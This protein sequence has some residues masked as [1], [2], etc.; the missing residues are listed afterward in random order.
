MRDDIPGIFYPG[1]CGLFGGARE[2]GESYEACIRRE[3]FEETSLD[4]SAFK[5]FNDCQL[6]F[7][8]FGYGVV[9]RIFFEHTIDPSLF[10]NIQLGEGRRADLVDAR[11]LLR[12]RKISPYDSFVLWQ[13]YVMRLQPDG[14]GGER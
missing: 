12:E 11:S 8:P 3:V 6:S 14:P 7:T 5:R 10:D 2:Q 1:H 13:H 9:D 4:L